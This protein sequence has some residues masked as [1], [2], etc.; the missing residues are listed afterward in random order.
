MRDRHEERRKERHLDR[1]M[2]RSGDMQ[3][4]MGNDKNAGLEK[5]AEK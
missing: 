5:E 4:N 2:G 3:R 1:D